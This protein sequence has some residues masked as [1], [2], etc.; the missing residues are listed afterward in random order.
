MKITL[1]GTGPSAG[2]PQ[3]GGRDGRGDWGRADPHEP[4]NRRTRSS[5][6]I[7]S[8]NGGRI[9]VDT[10]PDLRM[11]LINNGIGRI[12]AIF[13]THAHADHIAGL[14]EV[15]VL[16]RSLGAPIPIYGTEKTLD[17]LKQRFDY[18]FKDWNGTFFSRPVLT[19]TEITP[20]QRLTVDGLEILVLDQ[21]HGFGQSLGF[22]IGDFAYS[23]DVV[24]MS[25]ATL[26]ALKGIKYWVVG[27][28]TP[29]AD[30]PSHA[31]LETVRHW[32]ELLQPQRSIL[33]HMGALMDYQ[34]LRTT[35]PASIEPGYDGLVIDI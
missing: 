1:L 24:R 8:D 35:L 21:D 9:L 13:Y 19:P 33:T 12:D 14:D 15:R 23:T 26:S 27:C 34:T 30:H 5:I 20:G 25:E 32:I 4:R 7:Q 16:N 22:R 3:I 10:G 6:V 17:D 29:A 31:G 28:F 18:A 11:Q 2:L